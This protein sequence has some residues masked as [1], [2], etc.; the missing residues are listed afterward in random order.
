MLAVSDDGSGMSKDVIG[1]LFEPFFTTK[2]AGRGTGL[3]QATIYGI[4]KQNEG[5]INI[6]S[7]LGKGTTFKVYLPWFLGEAIA[8]TSESTSETPKGSWETVLLV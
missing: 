7:E 6:Y 5:F 2:K 1:H 3:G 8:S 4:D